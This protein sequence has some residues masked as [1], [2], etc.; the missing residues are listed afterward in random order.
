MKQE[1][2]NGGTNKTAVWCS[3]IRTVTKQLRSAELMTRERELAWPSQT[4]GLKMT[5]GWSR[6]AYIESRPAS[7][8]PANGCACLRLCLCLCLYLYL[9]QIS[10]LSPCL[11][12]CQRLCPCVCV[13]ATCR[14][15]SSERKP[16]VISMQI[17]YAAIWP[18]G[19]GPRR[20][21]EGSG[22][23]RGRTSGSSRPSSAGGARQ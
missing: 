22:K 12:Q 23:V 5:S 20:L 21:P 16:S 1:E 8:R 10:C 11:Y 4:T 18:N 19:K 13:P 14:R 6:Y 7:E 17:G 2:S 3:R 9:C 15:G